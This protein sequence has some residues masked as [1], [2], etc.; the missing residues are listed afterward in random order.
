MITTELSENERKVILYSANLQVRGGFADEQIRRKAVAEF[1]ACLQKEPFSLTAE[2]ARKAV[3]E[4]ASVDR[5]SIERDLRLEN[6]LNPVL[7]QLLDE[8]LLNRRDAEAFLTLSEEEQKK[9][10]EMFLKI[11]NVK[12]AADREHIHLGFKDALISVTLARTPAEANKLLEEALE[13][14]AQQM[15]AADKPGA[16]ATENKKDP[17]V[18]NAITKN[19]PDATKKLQRVLKRRGVEKSISTRSKQ[20]REEAVRELDEMIEA[21]SRL[22]A[23]I[24]GI[25]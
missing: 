8:K 23:L 9:A 16:A 20:E 19:L 18:R 17:I 4:I 3:K 24:E 22:K 15:Q 7:L 6:E 12:D 2:K 11:K 1:V 10:A 14:A 5:R 13:K 25:D 21:A